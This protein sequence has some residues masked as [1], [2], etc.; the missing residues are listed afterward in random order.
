MEVTNQ[1]SET[2]VAAISPLSR[3]LLAEGEARGVVIG[4]A[5]GIEKGIKHCCEY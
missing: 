1:M 3:E 4:E 2:D 5:I